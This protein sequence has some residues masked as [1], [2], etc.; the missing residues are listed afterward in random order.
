M[1]NGY[2]GKVLYV[3][4]TSGKTSVEEP[5]EV[6]YRMYFGGWGFIAH[7]LLNRAPKGVDPFAPENPIIFATG[8][9]SGAP[10]PGSGRHA[11]GAKSPLTG[12]FGE[13]DVGGFW[14]VELKRAGFDAVVITGKADEPV[15]L[16][17]KDGDVE[18][19]KA[20]HLWGKKTA[21]V[22]AAIHDELEDGKIRVAQCG[23]AGEN[24]V[25]YACVIH[26]V[27]RAAGRT[28]LGAVMGSKNLKAVA[29]RGTGTIEIADPDGAKE[30]VDYV[31]GLRERWAD[32]REH[33]TGG[34][35]VEMDEVGRLPTRNFQEG[36][37]EG[38]EKIAGTTMTERL[39]VGRDTCFACPISCKRVVKAEGEYE[40]DP[41][42]GGPE[43]ESLAALG[44][45]CGVDNLEAVA[46]AN[47]LCNA[48]GLD[49][50]STGVTIGWAMECFERGLLTT[51]DTG[52]LELKFGDH[53]MM[54]T[55]VERIAKRDGFGDLLAEGSLRAARTIGRETE[56]YAVQAKGQE[57][58]MHDPRFQ[59]GL[60]IGYATSPT[61]ADHMHNFHDSG[62]GSDAAAERIRSLGVFMD[63]VERDTL[64]TVKPV[65]AATMIRAA[66][67]NNCVGL[68]M[69]E[70][71][72]LPQLRKIVTAVAGWEV[73]DLELL[74]VGE[75]AL[76]LARLYNAREGLTPADDTH[77]PRFTEPLM[78]DGEEGASI[79][80]AQ[81][82]EAV[83]LYYEL[84]GWDK[85]TGAPTRAKLLELSLD[86]AVDLLER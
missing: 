24:L 32:F 1:P 86:W 56:R 79:P 64:P 55:L 22:Q 2:V 83:D 78:L 35:I 67:M 74:R 26:D 69:F 62:L 40:V 58:P 25:R 43:Y 65:L 50:I 54:T 75:R 73:T 66:V 10:I 13:A 15:Y 61:G 84:Q 38:A 70:P 34:G 3:N 45:I 80:Q 33:G 9:V 8:V 23:L 30:M 49:T 51:D 81:M 31:T 17:I 82:Q 60:G 20:E 5:N 44:S 4:L 76:A 21:D 72:R 47:Q 29:V 11:V 42:Y 68:C 16:W 41:A 36:K 28:G 39:L 59:F 19:R 52:G 85:T 57:Y 7:E 14:S 12:G 63:P 27:N 71:Y 77:H 48:Y 53:K 18:I 37:F 6:Y 46:F